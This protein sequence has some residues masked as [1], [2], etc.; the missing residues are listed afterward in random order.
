LGVNPKPRFLTVE[1]TKRERSIKQEDRLAKATGG[2]RNKGSGCYFFR[3]G[4][5]VSGEFL[6]EG[7]TTKAKSY[8]LKLTELR[9]ISNEAFRK[10]KTPAF[11]VSFE[12]GDRTEDWVCIRINEFQRFFE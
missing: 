1:P 2:K 8:S 12:T 6:I 5:V 9:K 11:A 3:P 4:D 10:N 7:K